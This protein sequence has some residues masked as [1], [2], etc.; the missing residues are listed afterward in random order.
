MFVIYIACTNTYTDRPTDCQP[1]SVMQG[2][3]DSLA[4]VATGAGVVLGKQVLLF[5]FVW[6][7]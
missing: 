1:I 3:S 5:K 7:E 2:A 4:F 6:D